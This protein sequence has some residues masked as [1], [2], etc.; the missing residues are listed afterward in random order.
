MSA[1]ERVRV[2]CV[3]WAGAAVSYSLLR[4]RPHRQTPSLS[5]AT[6]HERVELRQQDDAGLIVR[7]GVRDQRST[8]HSRAIDYQVRHVGGDVD[9][10]ASSCPHV[11]AECFTEMHFRFAFDHVHG[12]LDPAVQVRLRPRAIRKR[13]ECHAD[14][15]RS[16]RGA[17]EA[18]EVREALLPDVRVAGA[19]DLACGRSHV[20][21]FLSLT[22]EGQRRG[23][24]EPKCTARKRIA[25]VSSRQDGTGVYV[26]DADGSN[27]RFVFRPDFGTWLHT[28]E[29]TWAP[30]QQWLAYVKGLS[31]I[32]VRLDG[33]GE[34]VLGD[35]FAP[36]WSPDGQRIVFVWNRGIMVSNADGGDRRTVATGLD[37]A[38][39]PDGQRIAYAAGVPD[40]TFIYTVNADGSD[41]RRITTEMTNS[42]TTGDLSPV[43]S[44]DGHWIAF[45]R[46]YRLGCVNPLYCVATWDIFVTRSD[47]TDLR[48][49][50]T[51][52]KSVRPSW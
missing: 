36:S 2:G 37:P 6:L 31:L 5:P 45:Q 39:S 35:G 47:G 51:D 30:D 17:G 44:P 21:G 23:Q 16:H 50:T 40:T 26:M 32:R 52:G 28:S 13:D 46:A 15:A 11:L 19:N 38:W 25:Y 22:I 24:S 1:S 29:P 12:G 9:I 14:S 42:P 18:G 7:G 41:V 49:V 33:T 8:G 27:Q 34:R 48:K 3:I 4:E 20:T 10:L 43:W